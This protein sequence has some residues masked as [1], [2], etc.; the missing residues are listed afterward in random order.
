MP[1]QTGRKWQQRQGQARYTHAAP[2]QFNPG[3]FTDVCCLTSLSAFQPREWCGADIGCISCVPTPVAVLIRD[4]FVGL[5]F[6][7][8][9]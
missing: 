7:N 6:F 5:Y 3:R 9:T 2:V 1:W 4:S 8:Y